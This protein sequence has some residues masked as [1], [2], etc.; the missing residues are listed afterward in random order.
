ML[1]S[2][3]MH[4]LEDIHPLYIY[5]IKRNNVCCFVYIYIK[6]SK[7]EE[8]F[9]RPGLI[10]LYYI[11]IYTH[12]WAPDS[13]PPSFPNQCRGSL[14]T[15]HIVTSKWNCCWHGWKTEYMYCTVLFHIFPKVMREYSTHWSKSLSGALRSRTGAV[16]MWGILVI[17]YLPL[18]GMV[19]LYVQ[20]YYIPFTC[21]FLSIQHV[22]I[23]VKYTTFCILTPSELPPLRD[24]I[25]RTEGG[26]SDGW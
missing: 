16:C 11:Y 4:L 13:E 10:R 1:I 6:K 2:A 17:R 22:F 25:E 7:V 9:T 19:V 23:H 24:A 18:R 12:V 15:F 20:F 3:R 21:L 14:K 26:N 8:S 5:H